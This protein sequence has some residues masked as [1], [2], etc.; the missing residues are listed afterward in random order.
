MKRIDKGGE[1]KKMRTLFW[2]SFVLLLTLCLSSTGAMAQKRYGPGVT[3]TEIKL[4]QTMP[5]SGA[6]SVYGQIGRAQL[7]Y[8]KMINAK[9]GI[10]GRKIRLISRDDG[11][12]PPKTVEQV[13]KLV[14]REQVLA[15][16][17][18]IGTATN[19]AVRKYLNARKVPHLFVGGGDAVWG[20][21][22]NYPWTMGWGGSYQMEGRLY[23]EHI[24]ANRP[25]AKIAI[26]SIN[27]DYGRDLVKG[28]KDGLGARAGSMVVAEQTYEFSDPTVDS[29]IISLKTSGADTFFG[30]AFGKHASQVYRKMYDIGWRPQVYIGVAAAS[31]EG[32]LKPAGLH[33]A[34]GFI[35]AYYGKSPEFPSIR[36]DPAMQEY[37]AWARQWYPD[38]NEEDGIFTYGYQVAQAMEYVLRA[39]GDDLTREN[40]MRIATNMDRVELPMLYPGITANTSSTDY[41]PI[42]QFQMFQFDGKNWLPFGP[43]VGK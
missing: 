26:L 16:F 18:S 34:K 20:D 32:I 31:P 3:D 1:T 27:D 23:A 14:E 41:F 11:Y 12:L 22:K 37:F 40:I 5:Y 24:L 35:T 21:Y 2:Q 36:S 8:F 43:V 38:A 4:G 30:A 7:A 19:V 6:A 42:E 33:T 13:R 15:L 28:F 10:N 39:A 17:G 9:G 29:Q 25:N